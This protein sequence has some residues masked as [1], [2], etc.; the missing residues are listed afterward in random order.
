MYH[1][2]DLSILVTVIPLICDVLNGSKVL[3]D[4]ISVISSIISGFLKSGLSEP[5]FNIA[6]LYGI[7]LNGL[8]DTSLSLKWVNISWKIFSPTS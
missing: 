2:L 8:G 1:E 5:Y 6:S 4:K 7:L 3:L